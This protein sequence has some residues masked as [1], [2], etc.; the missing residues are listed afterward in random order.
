M[1]DNCRNWTAREWLA[2]CLMLA[3]MLFTVVSAWKRV[4]SPRDYTVR[5]A[6]NNAT[7]EATA[8]VHRLWGRAPTGVYCRA[9]P[10][11]SMLGSQY[12]NGSAICDIYIPEIGS[13]RLYCDTQPYADNLGCTINTVFGR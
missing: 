4:V 8:A 13:V 7:I 9:S 3:I 11:V 2:F 12:T 5:H 10:G 1:E 6:R